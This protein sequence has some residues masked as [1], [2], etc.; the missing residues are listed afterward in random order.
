MVQSSSNRANKEGVQSYCTERVTSVPLPGR[1][2]TAAPYAGFP[3]ASTSHPLSFVLHTAIY[4]CS[5]PACMHVPVPVPCLY[6][7]PRWPP[8][9]QVSSGLTCFNT[10]LFKAPSIHPSNHAITVRSLSSVGLRM[11]V[12]C[13]KRGGHPYVIA[14]HHSGGHGRTQ[15]KGHVIEQSG[16]SSRVFLE[17]SVVSLGICRPASKRPHTNSR[18]E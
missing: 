12:P 13:T 8:L 10:E 14:T 18:C 7:R 9:K 6:Q 2:A 4:S 17:H 16:A 11:K 15:K 3:T 5:N 1:R